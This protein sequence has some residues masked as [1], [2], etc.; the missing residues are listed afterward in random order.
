[1]TITIGLLLFPRVTQ[2]DLTGPHEVLARLPGARVVTIAT[3]LGPVRADTGLT[4]L[5]DVDFAGC[6]PLDV[7]V[8]PGGPG[9]IDATADAEVL[10]FVQA[11]A[12]T[13]R[14]VASVCTGAFLLGAAGL[15][16]G[17]RATTHW[18]FADLLPRYGAIP[19]D[20]RVVIDRDRITGAGVTAGIEAALAI[21]EALAGAA[22]AREIA[23]Q[24]E[25]DPAPATGD[26]H[27]RSA[28]PAQV[29]MLRARYT[30]TYA[31]RAAQAP[32]P[33]RP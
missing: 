8:V 5:P 14:L 24:I 21:V 32:A 7:L 31:A 33:T 20:A 10:A 15:L 17:Y 22:I 1:M 9:Q 25:Y 18:A 11:R 13:A 29:A 27:P 4:L 2:L 30:A 23:L 16:R 3:A 12:A 19:T 26:G 28:D 6:P